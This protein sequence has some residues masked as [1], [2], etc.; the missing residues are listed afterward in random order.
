MRSALLEEDSVY[1]I[2]H[3]TITNHLLQG[4]PGCI[5]LVRWLFLPHCIKEEVKG[6]YRGEFHSTDCLSGRFP[7]SSACDGIHLGMQV[8]LHSGTIN[9]NVLIFSY[10]T[11]FVLV[12]IYYH[13]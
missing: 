8:L 7:F 3:D 2:P 11:Y 1:Y 10:C 13:L 5:I 12:V 9:H 4:V 6:F